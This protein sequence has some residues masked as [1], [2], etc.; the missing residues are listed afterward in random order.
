MES[1]SAEK[2]A[3]ATVKRTGSGFQDEPPL[4]S[5]PPWAISR[6]QTSQAKRVVAGLRGQE[7]REGREGDAGGDQLRHPFRPR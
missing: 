5:R 3:K 4:V 1:S 6:P 7:Q 2:G